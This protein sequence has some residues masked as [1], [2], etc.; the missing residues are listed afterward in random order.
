MPRAY[1]DQKLFSNSRKAG[2]P[3]NQPRTARTK[4]ITTYHIPVKNADACVETLPNHAEPTSG[5]YA[6]QEARQANQQDP[7]QHE[8][9]QADF[10]NKAPSKRKQR[11]P[12]RARCIVLCVTLARIDNLN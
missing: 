2:S 7:C 11:S 6:K 4:T 3:P 12:L 9:W 1:R 8:L 5:D 10:S